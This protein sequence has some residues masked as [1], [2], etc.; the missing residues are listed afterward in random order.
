MTSVS[1]CEKCEVEYGAHTRLAGDRFTW[2]CATCAAA[3]TRYIRAEPT[4]HKGLMCTARKRFLKGLAH[5]AEPPTSLDWEA[6]EMQ[7]EQIQQDLFELADKWLSEKV[8]KADETESADG[9]IAMAAKTIQREREEC[10]HE[11]G[12]WRQLVNALEKLL[13]AHRIGKSPSEATLD[14]IRSLKKQLN[15]PDDRS[16]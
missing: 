7:H 2:L 9:A 5:A 6:W 4:W 16:E 13:V 11:L 10:D 12:R 3:W 14:T 8:G 1:A 15:V